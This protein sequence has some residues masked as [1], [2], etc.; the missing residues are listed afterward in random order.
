MSDAD[1]NRRKHNMARTVRTKVY[2]FDE[3]SEQAQKK[4]LESLYDINVDYDWW[5][6]VC[7]DAA[8]IGLKITSFDID[9]SSYCAA[10]FTSNATACAEA[11]KENHGDGCDTYKTANEFLQSW[12]SLVAKYSDG[13]RLDVV[14]EGNEYDFDGEADEL[15]KEF[16][17]SLSQDYLKML[18]D[19]Y[20]Y[21]TSEEAVKETI[22][23]NEYEFT[24]DGKLF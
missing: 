3:L 16:L 5:E 20:E 4:A 12:S 9:R 6:N 18:R 14:A 11:I 22:R 17:Y 15:E 8:Q 24:A 1:N 13:V 10:E 19:E 7:D 2:K 23:A 21:Q